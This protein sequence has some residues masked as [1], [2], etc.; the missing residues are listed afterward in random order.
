M[1]VD[2]WVVIFNWIQ[3]IDFY[4]LMNTLNISIVFFLIFKLLDHLFFL[5]LSN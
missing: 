1:D 3:N 5:L 2:K 4:N